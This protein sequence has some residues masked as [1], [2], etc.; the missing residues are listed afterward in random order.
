M[1]KYFFVAFL[2]IFGCQKATYNWYNGD[3]ESAKS[4]SNDKLILIDFYTET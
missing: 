1:K 4:T 3:F 2:I